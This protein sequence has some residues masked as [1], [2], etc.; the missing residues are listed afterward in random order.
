M[1]YSRLI[2]LRARSA[3]LR[4]FTALVHMDVTDDERAHIQTFDLKDSISIQVAL[5]LDQL[6]EGMCV[7]S[8]VTYGRRRA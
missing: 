3:R 1:M 5:H 8:R 4:C 2:R 6:R 7:V